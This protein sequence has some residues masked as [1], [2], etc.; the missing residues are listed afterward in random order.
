M[1]APAN[2]TGIFV[3]A[4]WKAGQ[5]SNF[6]QSH[7]YKKIILPE[8]YMLSNMFLLPLLIIYCH[9]AT[10]ATLHS[11]KAMLERNTNILSRYDLMLWCVLIL[12]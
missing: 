5:K 4:C 1:V 3:Q 7:G 11:T 2:T 6:P 10:P 12:K 9:S 8:F